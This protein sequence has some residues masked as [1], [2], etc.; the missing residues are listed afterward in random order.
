[1]SK[2]GAKKTHRTLQSFSTDLLNASYKNAQIKDLKD[3]KKIMKLKS[4]SRC[5]LVVKMRVI[6]RDCN[7]PQLNPGPIFMCRFTD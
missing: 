4:G 5:S 3:E 2:T 6:L 1:M 7:V